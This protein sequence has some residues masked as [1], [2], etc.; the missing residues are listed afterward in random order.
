MLDL[1]VRLAVGCGIY[2]PTI[3]FLTAVACALAAAVLLYLHYRVLRVEKWIKYLGWAFGVF[4]FQY[5]V[6]ALATIADR[7]RVGL[8]LKEPAQWLAQALGSPVNNFCFLATALALLGI[9]ASRPWETTQAKRSQ[10]IPGW[11]IVVGLFVTIPALIRPDELLYRLPDALFS[12]ACLGLVGFAMWQNSSPRRHPV[13]AAINLLG[14]ILYAIVNLIYA[15]NP[16]LA[17]RWKEEFA[18]PTSDA[19]AAA[20]PPSLAQDLTPLD[21]LDA[22]VFSLAFL[23]KITLFLGAL[24]LVIR[25]L[26]VWAPVPGEGLLHDITWG[27][28]IYL[29][30]KG[31]LRALGESVEA[32]L[33]ALCLRLTHSQPEQV[34]WWRWLRAAEDPRG[35]AAKRPLRRSLEVRRLPPSDQSVVAWVMREGFS[36]VFCADRTKDDFFSRRYLAYAPGMR[37]FVTVPI[38]YHGAVIACINVEWKDKRGYS[39][40]TISRIR[41]VAELLGPSLHARRQLIA[42][43]ELAKAFHTSPTRLGDAGEVGQSI[44]ALIRAVHQALSPLATGFLLELGFRWR[45]VGCNDAD[46]GERVSDQDAELNTKQLVDSLAPIPLVASVSIRREPVRS[47]EIEIGRFHLLIARG[48]D[49]DTRPSLAV[50]YLHRRTVAAMLADAVLDSV[51]A[52]LGAILSDLQVSLNQSATL[53]IEDCFQL[54]DKAARR[55]GMLWTVAKVPGHSAK[56]LGDRTDVAIVERLAQPH[57]ENGSQELAVYPLPLGTP[58][59]RAHTVLAVSRGAVPQLWFAVGRTTFDDE[60]AFESPWKLFVEGLAEAAESALT[61]VQNQRLVQSAKNIELVATRVETAGLLMHTVGNDAGA[62]IVGTERLAKLLGTNGNVDGETRDLVAGLS[63]AAV[64]LGQLSQAL[65]GNVPADKRGSIA[66][67]EAVELI[68]ALYAETF[69]AKR[70]GL[71]IDLDRHLTVGVPLDVG[72]IVLVTLVTNSIQALHN[73]GDIDIQAVVDGDLVRCD[74][75]DTGPGVP[76][77]LLYRLFEPGFSTKGPGAGIG[78]TLARNAMQRHGGDLELKSSQP[79]DTTFTILFPR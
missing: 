9:R 47:A 68:Q 45:W 12:A 4:F 34:A 20:L 26:L 66:L 78:L 76:A 40:T 77:E 6:P 8:D 59:G 62:L 50:D 30:D 42:L 79:G 36:A 10:L 37:S 71:T 17:D 67:I 72:Y 52:D 24:L 3:G 41:Q 13:I 64:N 2:K 74:V 56:L 43:D 23:L 19:A 7:W 21:C 48:H 27:R 11:L 32:D 70:L 1:I 63:K 38:R 73:D 25:R 55:A 58:A 60:L 57:A 35:K 51:Q 22:T 65:K 61:R 54:I 28:R 29:S 49:P 44:P 69:R 15:V 53:S 16:F 75:H 14:A 39:A 46:T 31:V 5:S 18:G 33:C